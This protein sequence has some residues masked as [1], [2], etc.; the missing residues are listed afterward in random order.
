M[1]ASDRASNRQAHRAYRCVITQETTTRASCSQLI[2]ERAGCRQRGALTEWPRQIDITMLWLKSVGCVYLYVNRW[3]TCKLPL[4]ARANAPRC[5]PQRR[6]QATTGAVRPPPSP[7]VEFQGRSTSWRRRFAAFAAGILRMDRAAPT[8]YIMGE[9]QKTPPKKRQRN[10]KYHESKNGPMA[11][12]RGLTF[13][14]LRRA[15]R[16][17]HAVFDDSFATWAVPRGTS[18]SNIVPSGKI[19]QEND[20]IGR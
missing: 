5:Q 18:F 6:S 20:T 15:T 3:H 13:P 10:I 7:S 16:L 8:P 1:Q 4:G 12:Q 2:A 11:I 14:S 9:T 17:P 19:I